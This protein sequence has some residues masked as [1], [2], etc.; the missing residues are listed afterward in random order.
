MVK[1][2]QPISRKEAERRANAL[3]LNFWTTDLTHVAD[4]LR[5]GLQYWQSLP[6]PLGCPD[7]KHFDML[8]IA[9]FL[10]DAFI[11]ER[12]PDDGVTPL[13]KTYFMGPRFEQ[14]LHISANQGQEFPLHEATPSFLLQMRELS[15]LIDAWRAPL[16]GNG[17]FEHFR[18]LSY[19]KYEALHL[20]LCDSTGA[21]FRV[22]TLWDFGPEKAL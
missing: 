3:P 15:L 12:A 11:S 14:R 5:D 4:A 7:I 1:S 13:F 10:K 19:V 16:V 22:I 18:G 9:R 6:A 20:P 8:A 17:N 21:I 2:I